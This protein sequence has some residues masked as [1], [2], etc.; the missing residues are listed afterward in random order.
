[1]QH[2]RDVVV[3]IAVRK[4][5]EELLLVDEIGDLAVDQV[6]ELVGPCE[7]IDRENARLAAGVER[8]DEIGADESGGAGDDDVHD[9]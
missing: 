8:A 3:E 7:V 2:C 9:G 6:A 1:M 4:A 5:G